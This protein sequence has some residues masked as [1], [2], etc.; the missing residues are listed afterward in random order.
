MKTSYNLA[1]QSPALQFQG[2]HPRKKTLAWVLA[3]LSTVSPFI[4]VISSALL[5][6]GCDQLTLTPYSTLF[7]SSKPVKIE[8]YNDLKLGGGSCEDGMM[9]YSSETDRKDLQAQSFGQI[10]LKEAKNLAEAAFREGYE[11]FEAGICKDGS[12]YFISVNQERMLQARQRGD[13]NLNPYFRLF[14][15]KPGAIRPIQIQHASHGQPRCAGT[16]WYEFYTESPKPGEPKQLFLP[17]NNVTDESLKKYP[18]VDG[19]TVMLTIKP[20]Q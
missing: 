17:T 13:R 19:D 11:F 10:N 12:F 15:G 4:P 3:A 16:G 9:I 1:A 6:T 14:Y 5:T 7:P 8:R 18:H 2:E 20:K